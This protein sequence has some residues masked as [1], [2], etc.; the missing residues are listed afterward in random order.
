MNSLN[1][2]VGNNEFSKHGIYRDDS[3]DRDTMKFLISTSFNHR[4]VTRRSFRQ[5]CTRYRFLPRL[6]LHDKTCFSLLVSNEGK[7]IELLGT[8]ARKKK[9]KRN[10]RRGTCFS[11][12]HF[13]FEPVSATFTT[14]LRSF[15]S[16]S[17]HFVSRNGKRTSKLR[18]PLLFQHSVLH[19]HHPRVDQL[20]IL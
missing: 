1:E 10:F 2:H 18:L 12:M 9:R 17:L 4:L 3:N 8:R 15:V 5:N 13:W 16:R 11:K 14:T 19:D 6:V 7:S 20:S